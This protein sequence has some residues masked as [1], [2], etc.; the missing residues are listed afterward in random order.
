MINNITD[1][2]SYGLFNSCLIV[3]TTLSASINRISS[4]LTQAWLSSSESEELKEIPFEIE[5]YSEAD[6]RAANFRIA[7]KI[8]KQTQKAVPFSSNN[9]DRSRKIIEEMA[10]KKGIHLDD[11][12]ELI[13]EFGKRL[14]K[15]R[16][17]NKKD[18]LKNL[19]S[20]F[21]EA[22]LG[23]KRTEKSGLGNC[24]EMT[25]LGLF[26]G[27]KK[28]IWATRL[29][30]A[31]IVNGDHAVMIIGREFG[32]DSCDYKTFGKTAVVAD[33]WAGKIFRASEI[34]NELRDFEYVDEK[35]GKPV[36]K[37]FNSEK[38]TL[39][40]EFGNI[41][42]PDDIDE[43]IDC[44][45]ISE[46]QVLLCCD[47]KYQLEKFHKEKESTKKLLKAIQIRKIC[48]KPEIYFLQK[49]ILLRDQL[50]YF[51]KLNE[52]K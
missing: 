45:E 15:N 29:E 16:D 42:F 33:L 23:V 40:I 26:K 3:G 1:T 37:L 4:L 9:L 30:I 51:I 35:T 38:Q 46:E 52:K 39:E 8:L 2:F 14:K 13:D 19:G 22:K 34:E 43:F 41:C 31:N 6:L 24:G 18:Y 10:N 21:K 17:L 44:Y 25:D 28:G 36:L 7:N 20:V 49:I 50:K 5:D 27:M 12:S 48:Q 11:Y 32:S 47:V